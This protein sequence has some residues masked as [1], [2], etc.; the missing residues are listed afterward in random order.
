MVNNQIDNKKISDTTTSTNE[1]STDQARTQETEEDKIE[2]IEKKEKVSTIKTDKQSI[3]KTLQ[4]SSEE[5]PPHKYDIKKMSKTNDPSKYYKS[6][7]DIN[8]ANVLN[9]KEFAHNEKSKYIYQEPVQMIFKNYISKFTPYDNILLYHNVGTGKCH[10]KDTPILMYDGTI[11]MVQDIQKGELLMGDDSTPRTV[12]SLATGID[13]MYKVTETYG[14]NYIV[15]E[16]HILCL[17]V[18][19]YPSLTFSDNTYVLNWIEDNKFKNYSVKCDNFNKKEKEQELHKLYNNINHEQILEISIKDYLNLPQ[20]QKNVLKGYKVQV[21]FPHKDVPVDPYIIGYWLCKHTEEQMDLD[22]IMCQDTIVLH[23]LHKNIGKYNLSLT[24]LNDDYSYFY[25]IAGTSDK[26]FTDIL[27]DLQIKDNS[28]IPHLYKCNSREIRLQLL[29]GIIDCY[30][31]YNISSN[32]YEFTLKTPI[33]ND[34]I[35]LCKSLGF[36][37]YIKNT[38]LIVRGKGIDEIPVLIPTKKAKQWKQIK[39]F[40][41]SDITVEYV[42]KDNYYGFTLDGNSRYLMGNFSVTHNTCTAITIAE[43]FKNYMANMDKQILVLVKNKNIEKNFINELLS[44]CTMGEYDIVSGVGMDEENENMQNKIRRYINKTYNIT[45]YGSFVNRVLGTKVY[46]K[47]EK[48]MLKATKRVPHQNEI[49]DLH[50]TIIIIDEVHNITNNDAYKALYKILSKSVNYR[51][52]LL[53]ATPIYDNPKE[54]IELSNLLN[55]KEADK[56]LPIREKV[57]EGPNAIMSNKDIPNLKLKTS[58]VKLNNYGKDRLIDAMKGKVSYLSMNIETNP[59]QIDIGIPLLNKEGSIKIVPCEMSEYQYNVYK[60]TLDIDVKSG[61]DDKTQIDDLETMSADENINEEDEKESSS[62]LYKNCSDASTMVYPNELFGEAG[63]SVL[64]KDNSCLKLPELKK[65]ST[66]LSLLLEN[67]EKSQGTVFVYSNYVNNGGVE[68]IKK[69][70][71][72]NGYSLY[73]K[74]V[75]NKKSFIVFSDKLSPEE[76]DKLR[77]RFNKSDNKNGDFIKIILGSPIISEGLTL[78]NVR[79]VH[80]IEPTWNM[81]KISQIIGRAVRNHSHDD[82]PPEKR[83][84]EIYKYASV[85]SNDPNSLYIDKEKYILSEE[86]DRSNK[87]IERLL[88]EI[89]FDCYIN[90]ERND[91]FYSKFTK[92]SAECDYNSCILQCAFKPTDK[93]IDETTYNINIHEFEK[94]AINKVKNLLNDYFKLYFIWKLDDIINKIKKYDSTISIQA[95][96]TALHD[97]VENKVV[98]TDKYNRDGYIIVKGDYYVFNPSN[99]DINTSLYKKIFDFETETNDLSFVKFLQTYKNVPTIK[100]TKQIEPTKKVPTT[101]KKKGLFTFQKKTKAKEIETIEVD[102]TFLLSDKDKLYNENIEKNNLIYGSFRSKS[103]PIH[104]DGKIEDK[105][106]IIDKRNMSEIE[107]AD[108]RKE[109]TGQWCG[110]F[111]KEELANIATALNI[112]QITKSDTKTSLCNLIQRHLQENNK[113]LK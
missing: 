19:G 93:N 52:I 18:E 69:I 36:A 10:A 97:V 21:S 17:K 15:N 14:D 31:Y 73:N 98:F 110:S 112:S 4:S 27:N 35:Y 65:Y 2:S 56:I 89:S 9:K 30:G 48:G 59:A 53:S 1:T 22:V 28:E 44:G 99:V 25:K 62:G 66:K 5:E 57:F 82:L 88:K 55:V 104:P 71:L 74:N 50:N 86:K 111:S 67:I 96:Y 13:N 12:T 101:E 77:K 70:L 37:C 107:L 40:T 106:K 68:L 90:K 83:K 43:G 47:D 79:Q 8:F 63:F 113:I 41:I 58:I 7:D 103:S 49:K 3:D 72:K 38:K 26:S 54:I 46:K 6:V 29:A 42:N 61:K 100:P 109:I 102:K 91:K 94:Y 60:K 64:D 45:T 33:L 87:V 85:Y 34:I 108:K 76:R 81:S 16:E 84:V 23:Y 11:K 95:I 32:I 20:C 92:N 24:K 80:I 75:Q 78:K 51:L 39:N 105:F